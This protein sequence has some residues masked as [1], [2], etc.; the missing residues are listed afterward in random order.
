MLDEIIVRLTNFCNERCKHCVYRSSPEFKTHLTPELAKMIHQWMPR[1]HI[2]NI[3]AMG[4]ELT[5]IPNYPELIKI[6]FDGIDQ[7]GIMTN[8]I[9]VRNDEAFDTFVD[10]VRSVI[11]RQFTVRVSQTQ[12]HSDKEYGIKAYEKLRLIFENKTGRFVQFSGYQETIVPFGRAFDNGIGIEKWRCHPQL[13]AMCDITMGKILLIDEEGFVHL[14]PL[15]ESRHE[16]ISHDSYDNMYKNIRKWRKDRIEKGM[17]CLSCS[18][19]GIGYCGLQIIADRP[20][21][22][23][24]C[25][26][27]NFSG[28]T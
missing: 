19:N 21:S 25:T 11:T 5:L 4:G 23:L 10:V 26:K 17:N 8:G 20:T 12:Y 13:G 28:A 22:I 24:N 6:L 2:T 15:G 9:F 1:S 7:G 16:H 27:G 14:C 18:E 3:T